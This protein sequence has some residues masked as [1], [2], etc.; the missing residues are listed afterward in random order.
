MRVRRETR[1]FMATDWKGSTGDNAP[2]IVLMRK[3]QMGKQ[4]ELHR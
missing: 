4:L 3:L 1:R 2:E